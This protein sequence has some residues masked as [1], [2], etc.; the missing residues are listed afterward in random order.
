MPQC[1]TALT[2]VDIWI[3]TMPDADFDYHFDGQ[4][5]AFYN[6]TKTA[7]T[8]HWDFGDGNSSELENPLHQYDQ[9]GSYDVK[10]DNHEQLRY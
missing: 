3:D 4:R 6:N 1:Q 10:T 2:K 9:N 5:A 7:R 8:F